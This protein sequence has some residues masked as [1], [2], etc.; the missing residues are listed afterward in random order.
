MAEDQVSASKGELGLDNEPSSGERKQM[1][2]NCS[3][4]LITV[5]FVAFLNKRNMTS[6]D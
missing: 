5:E 2:L 3:M 6:Y 4:N 1:K